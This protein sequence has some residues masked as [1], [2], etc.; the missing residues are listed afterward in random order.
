MPDKKVISSFIFFSLN[1]KKRIISILIIYLIIL[2]ILN[3]LISALIKN[4]VTIYIKYYALMNIVIL[5]KYK[6]RY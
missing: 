6:I 4:I 1:I 3:I 2:I 5:N